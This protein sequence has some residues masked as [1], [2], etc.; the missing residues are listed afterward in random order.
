MGAG[1]ESHILPREPEGGEQAMSY[2]VPYQGTKNRLAERIIDKLPAGERFVDLFAGGCAMTHAAIASGKYKRV[3]CNDKYPLIGIELFKM[4]VAGE[5]DDPKYAVIPSY[6]EFYERRYIDPWMIALYGFNNGTS[7]FAGKNGRMA[8]MMK[9]HNVN[10]LSEL[11]LLPHPAAKH[12][13]QC[14]QRLQHLKG[15][16]DLSDIEFTSIDYKDYT[17]QEGDIVYCDPPYKNTRYYIHAGAFDHD[18]FYEWART[19]DYP[20]YFSEYSAPDDFTCILEV[21]R[22]GINNPHGYAKNT[23]HIDKLFIHNKWQVK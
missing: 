17:W 2:G 19:R 11:D 12:P 20:V 8:T 22:G 13:H 10:N 16:V 7:Y 14:L 4:A 6:D 15:V 18:A 1:G 5:F 21:T 9:E 3:L 23:T